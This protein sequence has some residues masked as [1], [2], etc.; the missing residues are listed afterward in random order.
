MRTVRLSLV[1]ALLVTVFVGLSGMAV[2]QED[3]SRAGVFVTRTSEDHCSVGDFT[4]YI[5]QPSGAFQLRGMLNR[6]SVTYSDPRLDG[7]ETIGFNEDCFADGGCINWGAIEHEGKEGITWSGW[8]TGTEDPDAN[9]NIS[10]VMAGAGAYE[11]LTYV[12][13][14]SG[15]FG[16]PLDHHGVIYEGDP[17]PA[18]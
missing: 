1:G 13:H 17:P 6:C 5:E 2:A 18:E 11:G 3:H 7:L 16:E 15:L 8:Y 10:I 9:T 4:D 12:G 14:A